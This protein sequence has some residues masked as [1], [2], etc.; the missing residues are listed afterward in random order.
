M[1][2][3]WQ[4]GKIDM[5]ALPA[6]PHLADMHACRYFFITGTFNTVPVRDY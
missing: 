3:N 5:P 6:L 2:D 4:Y 1:G